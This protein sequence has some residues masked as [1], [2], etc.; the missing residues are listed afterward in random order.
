M[1][2]REESKALTQKVL[3]MASPNAAEV[4]LTGSERSGTRWANSAIT[5]N[6]VQFDRQLSVTVRVGNRQGTAN[7]RD[8]SDEGLRAMVAEATGNA[9]RANE[10]RNLPELLGPQEYLPVDAA[11]PQMVTFGAAERAQ[12]VR[13][14]IDIADDKRVLG[15]GYIPKVDQTTCRAN[16][17]GLFAYYRSADAGFVL[18]CRTPDG[19]GSGWAGITGIKDLSLIDPVALTNIAS[20]KAARS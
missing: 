3:D 14:S 18:T 13:E 11:L 15:Y 5:V 20:N 16:T 10:S 7:T 6:L 8:F 2:T 17:A 9:E 1:F 19:R 4:V 12:M